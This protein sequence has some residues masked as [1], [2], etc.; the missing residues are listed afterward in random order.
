MKIVTKLALALTVGAVAFGGAALAQN[1]GEAIQKRQDAMKGNGGAMRVL[2]PMARGDQPWNQA[3]AIQALETLSRN[4]SGV[5]ALFPQGSG[6][7]TGIKTAALP[8]IWEKWA[9][10]QNAAKAQADAANNLLTLARANDEAGFKSGF[11]AVGRA[12]G[13]CHEPFR[14]K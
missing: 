3:A 14:A 7:A 10:F 1:A 5:A 11:A 6:A 13:G 2:T 12:C 8:A 4:G 9:D